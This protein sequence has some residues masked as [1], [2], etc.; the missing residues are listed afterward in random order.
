MTNPRSTPTT[1][2]LV[3]QVLAICAD[4]LPPPVGPG[5]WYAAGA[6]AGPRIPHTPAELA[7]A[8]AHVATAQAP[9]LDATDAAELWMLDPRVGTRTKLA[10]ENVNLSSDTRARACAWLAG[11]G[12]DWPPSDPDTGWPRSMA[13][14]DLIDAMADH[15]HA[16]VAAPG[17]VIVEPSSLRALAP[18]P[19]AADLVA[20]GL[21]HRAASTR[22]GRD[23]VLTQELYERGSDRLR[24][25][26]QHTWLTD[27]AAA[28]DPLDAALAHRLAAYPAAARRTLASVSLPDRCAHPAAAAAVVGLQSPY[29]L[30]AQV[31]EWIDAGDDVGDTAALADAVAD[32]IDDFD[33]SADGRGRD[34]HHL[35]QLVAAHGSPRQLGRLCELLAAA[36]CP[37]TRSVRSVAAR[38]GLGPLDRV[39]V[40]AAARDGDELTSALTQLEPAEISAAVDLALDTAGE[41]HHAELLPVLWSQLGHWHQATV[42]RLARLIHIEFDHRWRHWLFESLSDDVVAFAVALLP[43]NEPGA[44][45]VA[46]GSIETGTVD[47]EI[48]MIL[49][50]VPRAHRVAMAMI[51]HRN[52]P[53]PAVAR[54]VAHDR[55]TALRWSRS[56]IS[57]NL[58]TDAH[59]E[60]LVELGYSWENTVAANLVS[61]DKLSPATRLSLAPHLEDPRSSLL[62]APL[63]GL[64]LDEDHLADIVTG[65]Q[66]LISRL[67]AG[68]LTANDPPGP[69]RAGELLRSLG[70]EAPMALV[71]ATKWARDDR[72]DHLGRLALDVP[73]LARFLRPEYP[74]LA[75]AL[76][77][78]LADRLGDDPAI[79]RVFC[80][81]ADGWEGTLAEVLDMTDA[82]R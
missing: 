38:W 76:V 39:R 16:A 25:R 51:E 3:T 23:R 69:T 18:H 27:R 74:H 81:L 13:V 37:H 47:H 45:D 50:Q 6:P 28:G 68:R 55:R 60:H 31:L 19:W 5:I 7:A 30:A 57:R 9:H 70:P 12:D 73:G 33:P 14:Q 29:V 20:L 78:P 35:S 71:N 67:L 48:A 72:M 65:S 62:V 40:A 64:T 10:F 46:L 61:C 66:P 54:I 77:G 75:R 53:A 34:E 15:P 82:A 17:W 42:R 41:S 52:L 36:D 11:R 2:N 8:P 24:A 79:W 22:R 80:E 56:A 4:A 59:V 26:M 1:E 44:A 63:D 58:P 21:A 43:T 49:Q 32:S